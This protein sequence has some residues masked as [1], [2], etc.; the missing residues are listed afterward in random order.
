MIE[1]DLIL[2]V[3][4]ELEGYYIIK[5]T[6]RM[7]N[8]GNVYFDYVLKKSL[9]LDPRDT[10]KIFEIKDDKIY[11]HPRLSYTLI[12]KLIDHYESKLEEK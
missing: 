9:L 10:A 2:E 6:L 1:K 12:K 5:G 3:E 7:T 4:N 11:T 8:E